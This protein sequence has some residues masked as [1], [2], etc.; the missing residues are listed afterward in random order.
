[1]SGYVSWRGGPLVAV[2]D[3]SPP[4]G[5]TGVLTGFVAGDAA[6]A[7]SPMEPTTRC[8]TL[9]DHLVAAFGAGAATPVA[10]HEQDWLA[11]PFIR[12]GYGATVLPG[13]EPDRSLLDRLPAGRRI[14]LATADLGAPHPGYMDGALCAGVAPADTLDSLDRP[15]R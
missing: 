6:R 7:A 12:G 2:V 14:A 13:Y 4:D 15:T 1:L 8:R 11:H 5:N 3:S 10:Y 9:I